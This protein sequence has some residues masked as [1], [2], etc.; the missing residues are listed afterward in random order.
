MQ[1]YYCNKER[2]RRFRA[3]LPRQVYWD[4]DMMR[5]NVLRVDYNTFLKDDEM[6]H[7]VLKQ[8]HLYGLAYFV[9]VPSINTDGAEISALA[10]RIGEI[11][12]TFYGKTWDVKSVPQSKN[13]AYL[14]S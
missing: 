1:I 5:A 13:I 9:N 8:L 7:R 3:P 2:D 12:Q 11:K 10:S 4:G 14:R 6:L